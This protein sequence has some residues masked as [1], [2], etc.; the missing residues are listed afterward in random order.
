MNE[1]NSTFSTGTWQA[2]RRLPGYVRLLCVIVAAIVIVALATSASRAPS[3]AANA[4]EAVALPGPLRDPS[5]P[6]ASAALSKDDQQPEVAA[7]TF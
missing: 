4:V 5:V 7:P 6:D 2:W 3:V 1:A